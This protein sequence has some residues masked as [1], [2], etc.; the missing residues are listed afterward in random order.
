MGIKTKMLAGFTVIGILL[1][2]S[3]AI[4]VYELSSMGNSMKRLLNDNLKSIEVS[5][6]MLS[7]SG[8][9]NQGV[10]LA[11]NGKPDAAKDK[12]EQGEILFK[13]SY[14]FAINNLTVDG[15]KRYVKVVDQCYAM[16]RIQVD[17]ALLSPNAKNID[18]YFSYFMPKQDELTQA[19]ED[20]IE[21]NQNAIYQNARQMEVGTTRAIMPSLMAILIGIIFVILFNYFVIF[22]FI[23]PIL[24]ITQGAENYVKHSIPFRVKIDTKDE[25]E[26]LNNSVEKLIVQNKS[27]KIDD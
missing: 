16:F 17:S 9:I 22:F 10:L 25:L 12:I 11:I 15:E 5:K 27:N 3:G 1:F 4:A 14:N 8:K 26:R 13:R 19:V 21:I 7:A 2:L 6:Q 23:N 18:W 20:L 24:R